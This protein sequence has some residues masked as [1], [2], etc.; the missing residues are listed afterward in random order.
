MTNIDDSPTNLSFDELEKHKEFIDIIEKTKSRAEE[1]E[2]RYKSVIEHSPLGTL[3]YTLDDEDNLIFA[4][5]NKSA[6]IILGVDLKSYVGKTIEQAFPALA[7]TEIPSEY[8]KVAKTGKEF[9]ANQIDYDYNKI[10]GAYEVWAYQV[11]PNNIAINFADI[12]ERLQKE[13]ELKESRQKF[14]A[15]FD[16]IEEGVALHEMLF[17]EDNNL[18]DFIWVDVNPKYEEIT[19][20]KRA[21]VIGKKGK[22]VIPNIEKRWYDLYERVTLTG[23]PENTVDYSEYLDK[24]WEVKAFRPLEGHFAIAMTDVTVRTKLQEEQLRN[25]QLLNETG[26]LAK[27]G[28]WEL[29][30]KTMTSYFSQET[31]RI[32]GLPLDADPPEG[33]EG[34]KYYPKEAQEKL[35]KLVQS[36]IENGEP[37]D[38]ELPFINEQ[39]KH[40][41]V[42]TIG[43]SEKKEGIVTRL[44][45]TFQD[46]SEKKK[47]ETELVQH[48]ENLEELVKERTAEI[49]EK[50]K[51]L[52]DQMKVFVGR[53]LKIIQLQNE[54]KMMRGKVE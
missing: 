1:S 21:D 27:I 28:G 7:D 43:L 48:R 50:S 10:R 31:K 46:I 41:W 29:D 16:N 42:R 15:L 51:K 26:R 40:L 44:Y 17:D 52:D 2:I 22:D 54:L 9:S 18:I 32:F 24:Y 20:L 13:E 25:D 35:Q 39:G 12:T 6:E 37:Y 34:I 53:E 36:A 23:T 30:V 4:G 11:S 5:S 47:W 19:Q 14:K 45:G 8:R 49:E 38:I 33:I 3:L